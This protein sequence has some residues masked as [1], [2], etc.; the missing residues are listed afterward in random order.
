MFRERRKRASQHIS[1]TIMN[2]N[3]LNALTPL[4]SC[5]GLKERVVLVSSFIYANFD[6]CPRVWMFLHKKSLNKTGSLHKRV[7]GFLLNYYENSYEQLL[8]KSGKCN[9]DLQEIRFLCTERYKTIN[10]LNHEKYF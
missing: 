2:G 10:S 8:E 1:A 3:Q 9:M 5:L 4:K 7:L 6:Y